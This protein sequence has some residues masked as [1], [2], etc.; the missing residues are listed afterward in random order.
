MTNPNTI[1]FTDIVYTGDQANNLRD[2]IA[3]IE[4]LLIPHLQKRLF[5]RDDKMN[6][7][8]LIDAETGEVIGMV[9]D[10]YGNI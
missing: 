6:V 8:V 5:D 3:M 10:H 1:Y 4:K 9:G 2:Y 7:K